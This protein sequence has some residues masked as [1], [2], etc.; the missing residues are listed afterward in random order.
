MS[1]LFE[2]TARRHPN[3][4]LLVSF[5][6]HCVLL[7]VWVWH[8]PIPAFV[9]PSSVALG[10]STKSYHL[11][12]LSRA[13]VVT[14]A[15]LPQAHVRPTP[16]KH[17]P[18]PERPQQAIPEQAVIAPIQGEESDHNA[19]A[20]TPFGALWSGPSNGHD[21][22]PAFPVVFPDPPISRAEISS[23][24]VQGD[25]VVE[26]TIDNQGNVIETKLLQSVGHGID[27]KIVA[28]LQGW[29][30]HPAMFDGRP[31]ASKHDVHFH[32]PA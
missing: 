3:R 19:K 15:P 18:Q 27:E 5:S 14:E 4:S 1:M 10:N 24:D 17:L 31:I 13:G 6:L 20:G 9:T 30:F 11:A 25:V 23:E 28:T 26:V 29:R 2:Q 8:H 21:V 12:Y 7:A 22:R 32:F 16:A